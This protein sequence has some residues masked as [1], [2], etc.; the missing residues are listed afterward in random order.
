MSVLYRMSDWQQYDG[1]PLDGTHWDARDRDWEPGRV[2]Y[3]WHMEDEAWW[4]NTSKYRLI[5]VYYDAVDLE[6]PPYVEPV[7][8]TTFLSSLP[9]DVVEDR[10]WP[11]ILDKWDTSNI[12]EITRIRGVCEAWRTWVDNNHGW[13]D[14]VHV[15]YIWRTGF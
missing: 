14:T 15:H 10:V 9:A 2:Q 5:E 6:L 13:N 4:V 3:E 1:G 11:L 12:R 8:E 7:E